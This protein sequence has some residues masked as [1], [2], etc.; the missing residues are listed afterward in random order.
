MNKPEYQA[1]LEKNKTQPLD[2][3]PS[4]QNGIPCYIAEPY[5]VVEHDKWYSIFR[6]YNAQYR[7]MSSGKY[8]EHDSTGKNITYT[9]KEAAFEACQIHN[10]EVNNGK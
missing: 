7:V 3:K 8:L 2:F 10:K 4:E 9:T 5:K 1:I 6:V